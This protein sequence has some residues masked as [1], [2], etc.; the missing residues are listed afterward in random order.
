MH[1][2]NRPRGSPRCCGGGPMES[3]PSTPLN[4]ISRRRTC[5]V[6]NLSAIFTASAFNVQVMKVLW[7]FRRRPSGRGARRPGGDG[8]NQAARR[9][10]DGRCAAI[11]TTPGGRSCCT[12]E[13]WTVL[14]SRRIRP[15]T[16][17]REFVGISS[18]AISH[19][20]IRVLIIDDDPRVRAAIS[21]P[22][23][24]RDCR[25]RV[26]ERTGDDIEL[27]HA[28]LPPAHSVTSRTAPGTAFTGAGTRA[29][30][31]PGG[32]PPRQV[33]GRMFA[34]AS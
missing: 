25:A 5:G 26:A 18:A 33:R 1:D 16:D 30:S 28:G 24:A 27:A 14:A 15:T 10:F 21:R 20:R 22:Q 29:R 12:V 34:I 31:T 8:W 13:S 32:E 11:G 7:P 19:G 17:C 4:R 6:T 23:V 9:S 3:L 2:Q